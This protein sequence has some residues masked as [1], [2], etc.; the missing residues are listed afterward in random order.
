[1]LSRKARKAG[2]WPLTA[3]VG[4]DSRS[5]QTLSGIKTSTPSRLCPSG[6]SSDTHCAARPLRVRFC[7]L[8]PRRCFGQIRRQ[9]DFAAPAIDV[10][11]QAAELAFENAHGNFRRLGAARPGARQLPL[12]V[13]VSGTAAQS[14]GGDHLGVGVAAV[15]SAMPGSAAMPAA[16]PAMLG[17]DVPPGMAGW[18]GGK[19]SG[20]WRP[21]AP[22][23]S[24]SALARRGWNRRSWVCNPTPPAPRHRPQ[25]GAARSAANA[26]VDARRTQG[27]GGR[28]WC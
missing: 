2:R 11:E 24:P 5:D 14:A 26:G 12:R 3:S 15:N 6:P 7:T 10:G 27:G 23:P 21:W 4:P 28:G 22:V 20:G 16:G 13:A 19:H 8:S 17:A 9:P 1:M 18:P 25:R